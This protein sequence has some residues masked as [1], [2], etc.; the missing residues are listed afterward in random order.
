[1]LFREDALPIAA[2]F[3]PCPETKAVNLVFL[4]ID[5]SFEQR[6]VEM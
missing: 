1:V 2:N 3:S 6:L 4:L 5:I